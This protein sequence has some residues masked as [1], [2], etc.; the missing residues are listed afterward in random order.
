MRAEHHEIRPRSAAE[1]AFIVMRALVTARLLWAR[2]GALPL[3]ALPAL[4]AVPADKIALAVERLCGEGI[5]EV[6]AADRTVRLT[7][8]TAAEIFQCLGQPTLVWPGATA[9][10]S[11]AGRL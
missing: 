8:R 11:G 9:D 5:A 7:E 1:V 10:S 3:D 2:R 6:S 4:A